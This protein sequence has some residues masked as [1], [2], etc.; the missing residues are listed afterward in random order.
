MQNGKSKIEN[1]SSLV[2]R[3]SSLSFQIDLAA[4]ATL[5]RWKDEGRIEAQEEAGMR[6]RN[7]YW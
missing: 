3:H 4:A 1:G 2:T 7:V 6:V 5:W